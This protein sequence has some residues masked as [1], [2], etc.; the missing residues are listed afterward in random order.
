MSRAAEVLAVC[1]GPGGIPKPEVESCA[2]TVEGLEGDG[3][4][5]HRHGGP[6]RAV[7]LLSEEAYE[8]L[9]DDDVDCTAPGTFGENVLTRGLDDST[10]RPGDRLRIGDEL[11]IEIHDVRAP[12]ATLKAVDRRFPELMVGRSG[13]VCRVVEPG[14]LRRGATIERLPAKP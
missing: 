5:F 1:V 3:H 7:C 12:C 11:V 10:L 4:R 8:A 14:I 2:V 6:N 9:R 13:W